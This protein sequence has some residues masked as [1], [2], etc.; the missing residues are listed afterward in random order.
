MKTS[1]IIVS[2]FISRIV[3]AGHI[4]IDS[5][6]IDLLKERGIKLDIG[7][8][9]VLNQHLRENKAEDNSL[10]SVNL[11]CKHTALKKKDICEISELSF[12]KK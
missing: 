9:V 6:G 3:L 12:R 2:L 11:V 10:Y 8:E 1:L 7:S 5:N 4:I